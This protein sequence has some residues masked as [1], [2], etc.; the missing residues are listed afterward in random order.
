MKCDFSLTPLLS[1]SSHV[2]PPPALLF[3]FSSISSFHPLISPLHLSCY[4][5]VIQLR[6][7]YSFIKQ[8]MN[9]WA[10]VHARRSD[11]VVAED[12][13]P[14]DNRYALKSFK[15]WHLNQNGC[16]FIGFMVMPL[17]N[18]ARWTEKQPRGALCGEWARSLI[19][20]ISLH[21]P[22]SPGHSFIY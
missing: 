1:S 17:V 21:L 4:I 13:M 5:C 12:A 8:R 11:D 18:G 3:F 6:L 14:W 9:E 19:T 20:Y 2:P 22:L 10:R 15:R 16:D 7:F